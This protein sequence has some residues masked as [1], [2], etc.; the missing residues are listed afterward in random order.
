MYAGLQGSNESCDEPQ[1]QQQQQQ[2]PTTHCP[3]LVAFSCGAYGACLCDGSEVGVQAFAFF[4]VCINS[5]ST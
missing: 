3:L 5:C 2:Q 4:D 1:Q